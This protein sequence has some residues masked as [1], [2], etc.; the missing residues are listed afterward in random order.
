MKEELHSLKMEEGANM[1]E[2]VSAF[3]KCIVDL[4]RTYEVH[5]L[6]DKAVMLLTCLPSS[7]KHFCMRLIFSKG[8]L[9]YETVMQDILM[10][11]MMLQ[12]FGDGS[13]SKGLVARTKGSGDDEECFECGSKDHWKRNCPVWK[14][15]WNKMKNDELL[16]ITDEKCNR[17]VMKFFSD[18]GS[19]SVWIL[20]SSCSFHVCSNRKE[21]DTY[22]EM[23]EVIESKDK[24]HK[25]EVK[26]RSE[27]KE[28]IKPAQGFGW[29]DNVDSTT[30]QSAFGSMKQEGLGGPSLALV[31]APSGKG[32]L[33]MVEL[34]Q[35]TR[36]I[37]KR[38]K[39]KWKQRVVAIR[40]SRRE[41][42]V[43]RRR[44][45][46][47]GRFNHATNPFWSRARVAFSVSSD[48]SPCE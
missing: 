6:E 24:V 32:F 22:E 46:Q 48:Q 29:K 30:F 19:T 42:E 41:E 9:K 11:D 4:Q 7:Y 45:V 8:P 17:E 40:S 38:L 1:M 21:F 39:R 20:D 33:A 13:R 43:I 3:N 34:L 26:T 35:I 15:K 36:M 2:H 37:S 31:G 23:K 44:R 18:E 16:M 25:G 27:A 5:K 14:E 47:T 12:C 10:H 28:S